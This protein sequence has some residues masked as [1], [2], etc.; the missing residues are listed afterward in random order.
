MSRK[1]TESSGRANVTR[2]SWSSAKY[3]MQSKTA[4]HRMKFQTQIK[5][6]RYTKII[7]T[8]KQKSS[9]KNF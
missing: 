6:P 7:D 9:T 1:A 8:E 2:R 3:A 4:E 5:A